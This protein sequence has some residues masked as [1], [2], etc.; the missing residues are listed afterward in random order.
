MPL[1]IRGVPTGQQSFSQ[2]NTISE[3]QKPAFPSAL[4][5]WLTIENLLGILSIE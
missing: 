2:D 4:L 1:V 5:S 3:Y